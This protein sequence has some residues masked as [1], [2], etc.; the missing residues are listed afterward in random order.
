MTDLSELI[1]SL[2]IAAAIY[3]INSLGSKKKQ[4]AKNQ[5]IP[6]DFDPDE[7][8]EE[9]EKDV[10]EISLDDLFQELRREAAERKKTFAKEEGDYIPRAS[11]SPEPP[12]Q[13]RPK[14]IAPKAAAVVSKPVAMMTPESE[15]MRVTSPVSDM[16]EVPEINEAPFDIEDV[17][18]RQVVIA[19]EILN[20]KY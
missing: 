3:A 10:R 17:D 13:P 7:D 2:I 6:E 20:R 5:H 9:I 15:G 19:S 1:I 11:R 18:W 8:I 4:K 16:P 14:P 12:V